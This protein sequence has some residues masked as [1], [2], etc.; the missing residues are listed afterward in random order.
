MNER[1]KSETDQEKKNIINEEI[2]NVIN[3][4]ALNA[5]VILKNNKYNSNQI[6]YACNIYLKNINNL[7][8][9]NYSDDLNK[10]YMVYLNFINNKLNYLKDLYKN[11]NIIMEKIECVQKEYNYKLNQIM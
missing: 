4:V 6:L 9:I 1:I 10:G 8:N 2:K 3:N 5:N 7:S 11:N